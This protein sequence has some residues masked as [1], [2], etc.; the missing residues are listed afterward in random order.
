M[1]VRRYDVNSI[2]TKSS[3]YAQYP[4]VT[5]RQTDR[6]EDGNV[7]S[8]PERS[9][10]QHKIFE[11]VCAVV[12]TELLVK[13]TTAISLRVTCNSVRSQYVSTQFHVFTT[14]LAE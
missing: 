6:Q 10:E 8:L 1:A 12:T 13:R 11:T 4:R 5:D 2:W 9:L 3:V 14:L 7:I